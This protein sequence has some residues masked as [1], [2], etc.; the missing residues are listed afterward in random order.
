MIK[1]LNTILL[2]IPVLAF[3]NTKPSMAQMWMDVIF[4]IIVMIILKVTQL[5]N[6][7]KFILFAIYILSG[8]ITQ[9]IWVSVILFIAFFLYFNKAKL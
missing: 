2:L 3:A 5:P 1:L 6:K 4:L 9:T 7:H 8:I